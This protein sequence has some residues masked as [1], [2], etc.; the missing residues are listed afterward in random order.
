MFKYCVDKDYTIREVLDKFEA[1]N[2]RCVMVLNDHEKLLGVISQ[3]DILRA[4]AS[5]LDLYARV[6]NIINSSFLYIQERDLKKAYPIFKSKNISLL[7][8]VND[9]F[10]LKGIITLGDIFNYLEGEIKE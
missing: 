10:K 5:G 8:I 7:P 9:E 1:N 4:L 3:G 6:E 2:E